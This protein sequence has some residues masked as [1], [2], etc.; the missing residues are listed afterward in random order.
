MVWPKDGWSGYGMMAPAGPQGEPGADGD[1]ATIAIGTVAAVP[2]GTP[3]T[4]TNS[5][6]PG[7]AVLDF[8]L[9]TGQTGAP[10]SNGL[11][12]ADGLD[13]D[14][15]YVYIAYASAAD[16]TDFTMVFNSALNYIAILSTDIAIPSPDAADFA[17]LWKNYKGATGPAGPV[18]EAL[19][20]G[21]TYGRKDAAWVAVGGGGHIIQEETTP[22]TAR[23]NLR[24]AGAG[25]T[26]TDDAGN[27]VTIVTIP[28]GGGSGG[29]S[30]LVSQVFS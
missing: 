18:E 14:N 12:G 29:G 5:G 17:G 9:E 3:P 27:N 30:F 4:V 26:A 7:A 8:E 23:A 19:S 24:F 15:A 6:P 28:G 21:T 10:G 11:D 2:Y 16:G 13:G 1:D 22:L 20:D 25:V